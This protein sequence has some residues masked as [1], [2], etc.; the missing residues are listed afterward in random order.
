MVYAPSND[1]P[2]LQSATAGDYL[3]NEASEES[4]IEDQGE[5]LFGIQ[6]IE[7]EAKAK[8]SAQQLA[9]LLAAFETVI[10]QDKQDHD[11]AE[12]LGWPEIPPLAP[13][14]AESDKDSFS[15]IKRAGQYVDFNQ[16]LAMGIYKE[17]LANSKSLLC[18][19][20][21]HL[22]LGNNVCTGLIPW[23][24]T[25]GHLQSAWR[26]LTELRRR[27]NRFRDDLWNVRHDQW[28][29]AW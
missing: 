27:Y 23:R 22:A 25:R 15:K 2:L 18:T 13:E 24:E 7:A 12:W 16:E 9:H 1:E 4:Y 10:W 19:T 20:L 29:S 5:T 26:G 8:T 21:A 11:H 6:R 14:E 17:V 28:Y 3:G